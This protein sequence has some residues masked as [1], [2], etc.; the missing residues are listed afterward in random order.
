MKKTMKKGEVEVVVEQV[1]APAPVKIESQEDILKD[2]RELLRNNA[3]KV[4]DNSKVEE[5]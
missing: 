3:T 2:I 4:E 5:K 1:P